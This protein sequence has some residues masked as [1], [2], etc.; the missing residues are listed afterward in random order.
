LGQK[1][2]PSAT[3]RQRI[4][5]SQAKHRSLAGHV[6][7]ARRL[8]ALVPF[9]DY[10]D[11]RF[12]AC[13][14]APE[15]VVARRRTALARLSETYKTRFAETIRRTAEAKQELSDLRFTAAYRVPFQFRRMV[16]A[17]L[18]SGSFL[19]SSDG[20]TVTDL[21]G[22]RFFDLSG[23]YGVNLF[24]YD[25]YKRAIARGAARAQEL[26]PV[27]GSSFHVSAM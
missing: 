21:D 8:A 1:P 11:A 19:Q 10:D 23:S 2:A 14:G 24:G 18:P 13:D 17:N 15:P 6:R 20:V 5:L 3:L 26:G 25:F 9:Y 16:Q 7:L 4:D 12:F 22:N 27:L